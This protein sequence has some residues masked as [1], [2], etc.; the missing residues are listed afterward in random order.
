MYSIV[1]SY[2]WTSPIAVGTC[3][4]LFYSIKRRITLKL[5]AQREGYYSAE[6]KKVSGA[7]QI[8][9]QDKSL[10]KLQKE[11]AYFRDDAKVK[12]NQDRFK[13][14]V[15]KYFKQNPEKNHLD[16][17]AEKLNIVVLFEYFKDGE[18]I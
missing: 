10:E 15:E 11:E 5:D 17:F 13:G 16:F 8:I 6:L 18:R 3:L 12:A 7:V 1:I 9:I 14:L 2:R 4:S